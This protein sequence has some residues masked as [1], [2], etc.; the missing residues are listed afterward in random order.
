MLFQWFEGVQFPV[1][2]S[3]DQK[4]KTEERKEREKADRENFFCVR[5]VSSLAAIIKLSSKCRASFFYYLLSADTEGLRKLCNVIEIENN[6]LVFLV[7]TEKSLIQ[8]FLR[9]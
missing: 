1:V 6:D 7:T 2:V 9:S 5:E 4:T 3:E 8:W